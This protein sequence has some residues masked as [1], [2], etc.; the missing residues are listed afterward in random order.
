MNGDKKSAHSSKKLLTC[1]GHQRSSS[2]TNM[3]RSFSHVSSPAC[4]QPKMSTHTHSPPPPPSMHT[5]G[6]TAHDQ[7]SKGRIRADRHPPHHCALLDP[8]PNS[9]HRRPFPSLPPPGSNSYLSRAIRVDTRRPRPASAWG[10]IQVTCIRVL[11]C[12]WIRNFWIRYSSCR[13]P[14][15]RIQLC[16]V[17]PSSLHLPFLWLFFVLRVFMM[18]VRLRLCDV[19]FH[20]VNQLNAVSSSALNTNDYA[21]YEQQQY[22]ASF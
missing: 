22:G 9:Y 4:L 11:R 6:V 16:Q 8:V 7:K 5:Y 2:T 15:G 17:S 14:S 18:A 19:G 10:C 3:G 21:M 12:R 13:I 20:W 1:S